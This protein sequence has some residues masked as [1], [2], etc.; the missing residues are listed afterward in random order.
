MAVLVT[1]YIKPLEK[2]KKVKNALF[3]KNQQTMR[4][5]EIIKDKWRYIGY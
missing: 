2:Y 1:T 5:S 4:K 3:A